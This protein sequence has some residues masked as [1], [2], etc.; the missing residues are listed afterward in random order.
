MNQD[1]ILELFPRLHI[2]LIGDWKEIQQP[3]NIQETLKVFS[4][5]IN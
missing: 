1:Q 4:E 5:K 2:V 3:I